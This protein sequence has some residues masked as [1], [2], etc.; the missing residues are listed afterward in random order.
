MASWVRTYE[1]GKEVPTTKNTCGKDHQLDIQRLRAVARWRLPLSMDDPLR[2]YPLGVPLWGKGRSPPGFSFLGL[3]VS[4]D[5]N[6]L[7]SLK[8]GPSS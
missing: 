7:L 4:N 8:S 5:L 2:Q 1:P 6:I 3:W